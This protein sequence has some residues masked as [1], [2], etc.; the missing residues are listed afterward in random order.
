MSAVSRKITES[1]LSFCSF[2]VDEVTVD[3]IDITMA[4]DEIQ[5]HSAVTANIGGKGVLGPVVTLLQFQSAMEVTMKAAISSNNT[6]CVNLDIQDTHFQVNEVNIQLIETYVEA[7]IGKRTVPVPG[8]R[9]PPDPRN[10]TIS[11]TMSTSMLKTLLIYV[12]KQSSVKVSVLHQP[13]MNDLEA[14]ITKIAYTFQKD[15]LLRVF[16][17]V[18]ITKD[19]KDFATGK[20]VSAEK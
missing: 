9:L 1:M 10:A 2:K 4:A 17:E 5:V 7:N 16:Y 15:K 3:S 14:N 18:K 20:T 19:G 13:Q 11:V 12:A 6:Q 8:S